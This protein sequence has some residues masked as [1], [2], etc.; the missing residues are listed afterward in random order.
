MRYIYWIPVLSIAVLLGAGLCGCPAKTPPVASF[1]ATPSSGEAPLAV[2]FTD[3]SQPGSAAIT[4]WSWVF[5]D[6]GTSSEASPAHTYEDAG[7]YTVKLTVTTSIGSNTASSVVTVVEGPQAAFTAT[8]TAGAAPLAVAFTD[9]STAG[10]AAI[11]AWAWDFGDGASGTEQNPAHTYAAKGTYTVSLTVTA[12]SSSDTATRANYIVVSIGPTAAFSAAP[13]TGSAALDVAFA[14]ESV[15]GDSPITAWAWNFG[16]T[17]TATIANPMHT[18]AAAGVYTVSLTV[19]TAAGSSTATRTGYITVTAP[20]AWLNTY[21]LADAEGGALSVLTAAGGGYVATVMTGGYDWGTLSLMKVDAD[22]EVAWEQTG[23]TGYVDYLGKPMAAA[24]DGGYVLAMSEQP[25]DS[26]VDAKGYFDFALD[27][28]LRKFDADGEPVWDQAFDYSDEDIL[29]SV[30]RTQ[31]GGFIVA[32]KTCDWAVGTTPE[33]RGLFLLKTDAEGN[34]TWVK[35]FDI[36][37]AALP[38]FGETAV[39]VAQLKNGGYVIAASLE[40]VVGSEIS[41]LLLWTGADGK[42]IKRTNYALWNG[43]FVMSVAATPD[44]GCIVGGFGIFGPYEEDPLEDIDAVPFLLKV[45]AAGVKQWGKT[46]AHNRTSAAFNVQPVADGGYIA[47]GAYG[48]VDL[49]DLDF[50]LLNSLLLKID[51]NGNQVWSKN[52]ETGKAGAALSVTEA[53][54]HGFAVAGVAFDEADRA[55]VLLIKTDAQGNSGE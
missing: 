9:Q 12:G 6:G 30:A 40:V 33:K 29:G 55:S 14:D 44:G 27:I 8:P 5:G 26:A 51:A 47:A 10:S 48:D 49:R 54:D 25:A 36:Q 24:A 41:V 4:G 21:P 3:T 7:T 11:S 42:E 31:D 16:D 35:T 39:H 50:T 1:T 46:Y 37:V 52:Y 32:G 2:Q 38:E 34:Q 17:G 28:V 22:G 23:G 43:N 19:T 20:V 18:Y 13:L 45:E 15:P 53:S